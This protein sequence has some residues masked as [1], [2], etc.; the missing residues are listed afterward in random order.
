VSTA[1]WFL[2][3]LALLFFLTSLVL[4][5]STIFESRSRHSAQ[6]LR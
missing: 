2:Y 4:G 6:A 5:S 3:N 1:V